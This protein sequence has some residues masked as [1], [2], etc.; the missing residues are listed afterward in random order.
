[1][2]IMNYLS[3][4][5]YNLFKLYCVVFLVIWLGVTDI[6]LPIMLLTD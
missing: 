2:K 3:V 5:T 6:M 1:M 4:A